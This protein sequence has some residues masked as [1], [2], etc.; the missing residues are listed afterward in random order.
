VDL[1]R[2][3]AKPGPGFKSLLRQTLYRKI[4]GK[5]RTKEEE[6]QFLKRRIDKLQ[7]F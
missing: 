3:G 7:I 6:L 1:K 2:F 4:N 5:I